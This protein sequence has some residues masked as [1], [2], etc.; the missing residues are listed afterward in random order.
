MI[1]DGSII[2]PG[3]GQKAGYENDVRDVAGGQ[4]NQIPE[5]RTKPD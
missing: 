3:K 4:V 5:K 1:Y 2:L